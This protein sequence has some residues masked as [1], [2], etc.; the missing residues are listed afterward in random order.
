MDVS[1][2]VRRISA[3]VSGSI[4]KRAARLRELGPFD[5]VL[6]GGLFDYLPDR[7]AATLTRTVIERLLAPGGRFFFI[8]IC[9]G[10]PFRHWIEY[11]ADWTLIERSEAQVATLI[12]AASTRH[13]CDFALER[14]A[15]HL[16]I[17]ATVQRRA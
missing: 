13:P 16:S 15:S 3:L 9:A 17:L 14:D 6:A 5:L 1:A 4:F 10:N 8:N 7:A 11:L 2:I 12:E